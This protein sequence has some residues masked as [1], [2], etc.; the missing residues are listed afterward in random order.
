MYHL[1]SLRGT[2]L[3][4]FATQ[5]WSLATQYVVNYHLTLTVHTRTHTP[6]RT[7]VQ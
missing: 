2:N 7:Y 5:K 1:C 3:I 6:I 4:S